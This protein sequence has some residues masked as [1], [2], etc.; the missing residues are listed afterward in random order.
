MRRFGR[1]LADLRRRVVPLPDEV[2]HEF[3]GSGEQVLLS[4]HPSFRSFVVE[5]T[6]LF[7][8]FFAV[9]IAFLGITFNGSTMASGVLLLGLALVLLVL[10]FRRLAER[11]TS[12]VV[13]DARIMRIKGIVS[14][15]AHSIPWVRVTDL[16]IDQSLT[17]RLFGYATLH[18]ESANE[19]SGLRDLEGVSDPLRFN[20]YVV[21]M[22]VAKQGT[23]EPVWRVAGEPGPPSMPR[24]LRRVRMSRRR[25]GDETAGGQRADVAER[26]PRAERAR[27]PGTR[28]VRRPPGGTPSTVTPSTVTPSTAT[29]STAAAPAAAAAASAASGNA[30]RPNAVEAEIGELD[31]ETIAARLRGSSDPALHWADDDRPS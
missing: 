22:V 25:R 13:T 4:D 18:I 16:T 7:L 31:A 1:G 10:L 23:T 30:D 5:N 3:L 20:Q 21:D 24:G 2:I 26:E 11:Y 17:G 9:G 19:D 6:L 29:L 27:M 12:Y 8:G 15:R 14:R 28:T